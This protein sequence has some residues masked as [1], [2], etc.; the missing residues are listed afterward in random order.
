MRLSRDRE[1]EHCFSVHDFRRLA[2]RRLPRVIFEAIEAAA[3]D[4]WTR[5]RNTDAFATYELS[6]RYLVDVSNVDPSTTILGE[7]VASPV[8]IAP[9][10][11]N[12]VYHPDGELGVA[13]AASAAGTIYSLSAAA[14]TSI[15]AIGQATDTAKWFQIYVWR[16]RGILRDFIDRCR[17]QRYSALCLTVDSPVLGN[18]EID[19]RNGIQVPP[20]LRLGGMIEAAMHPRWVQGY[21]R[22]P[23]IDMVN[24]TAT[25]GA[26]GAAGAELSDLVS[27]QID[28]SV[29]WRD[30]EWMIGYWN[31][32]FAVKGIQHPGDA[33]QAARLGVGAIVVSN[34]GGRQLDGAAATI[35]LLP[36]IVDAVAPDVEVLLDSGIRRGTDVLKAIALGARACMIGRPYLYGLAAGGEAG[37]RRVLDLIQAEIY[38]DLALLGCN[39]LDSL[40][41][42]AIARAAIPT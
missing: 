22:Q 38:R 5:H 40:D 29:T 27:S 32:P 33:R 26:P 11:L 4:A 3:D 16:D 12:R 18:R 37:V 30:L 23:R 41:R 13:R 7:R 42:S 17:E 20:R 19:Q 14:S 39:T 35:D 34:H 28:A 15:E 2:R 25:A 24:V 10:A 8:M 36:S 31:G 6:G 9:T 1:L 21:L